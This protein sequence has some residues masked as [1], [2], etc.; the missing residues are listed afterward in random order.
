MYRRLCIAVVAL[1]ILTPSAAAANKPAPTR[2]PG[3]AHW[4]IRNGGRFSWTPSKTEPYSACG[5]PTAGHAACTAIIDP[6]GSIISTEGSTG[7]AAPRRRPVRDKQHRGNK[8]NGGPYTPTGL[9]EAYDLPSESAG[10]GQTVGIVDAF[11]DPDAESD[12]AKYRAYFGLSA[13]TTA[14]GCFRKVNQTGG[15]TASRTPPPSPG[16][17]RSP[18]TWTWSQRCAPNATSSWSRRPMPKDM[19]TWMRLRTRR[20][21]WGPPWLTTAGGGRSSQ[22]RPHWTR[23]LIT[24]VSRSRWLAATPATSS[25]IRQRRRL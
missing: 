14:N 21:D 12:L 23:T 18:S 20:V 11:N 17:A 2:L 10:S 19:P 24:P 8:L 25:P 9:R 7:Q 4:R 5:R 15:T 13:C 16:R 22:A 1:C 6:P 3:S